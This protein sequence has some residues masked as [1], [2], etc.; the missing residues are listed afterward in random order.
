MQL[1]HLSLKS[2]IT[3]WVAV[4]TCNYLSPEYVKHTVQIYYMF[5][6]YYYE[7]IVIFLA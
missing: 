1:K 6:I 3:V 7:A 5:D 2:T 4:V